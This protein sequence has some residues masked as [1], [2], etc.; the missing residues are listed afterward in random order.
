MNETTVLELRSFGLDGLA[1][2]ARPLQEPGPG[3]V[4]M[5]VTDEEYLKVVLLVLLGLPGLSIAL[6]VWVWIRRRR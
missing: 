4:R 3:Q 2:A 1:E 5:Q 6:G